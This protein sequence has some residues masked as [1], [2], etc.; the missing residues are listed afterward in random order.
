MDSKQDILAVG[1]IL[2]DPG[3]APQL[4]FRHLQG[5]SVAFALTFTLLC[6]HQVTAG[7][8]RRRRL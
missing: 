4:F 3:Y 1:T 6:I 7:F 5:I 2:T 8:V